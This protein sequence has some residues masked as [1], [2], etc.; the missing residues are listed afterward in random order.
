MEDAPQRLRSLT[1]DGIRDVL[2]GTAL[3]LSAQIQDQGEIQRRYESMAIT[4]TPYLDEA[5]DLSEAVMPY[6]YPPEGSENALELEAANQSLVAKGTINLS[7]DLASTIFPPNGNFFENRKT[8]ALEKQFEEQQAAAEAMSEEGE[9]DSEA[10]AAEVM[11]QITRINNLIIAR[12]EKIKS[13]IQ[14][15]PDAYNF[16][17]A[18]IHCVF[19]GNVCFAKP[20]L[21]SSKIYTL[22]DYVS[23]FDNTGE[24][25]EVIVRDAVHISKFEKRDLTNLFGTSDSTVFEEAGLT[26]IPVYTRQIRRYDHWE[27]Q[28]E[29]AGKRFKKME[30]KEELD[31]PPFIVM[32]FFLLPGKDY[33]IGWLTHN[34][35]DIIQFENMNLTLNTMIQA[36]SKLIAMFPVEM[37]LSKEEIEGRLGFQAHFGDAGKAQ[38]IYADISKNLGSI[39]TFYE[40]ARQTIMTAFL[41]NESVVRNAERVTQAEILEV[42]KGLKKILGGIYL[43]AG[44]RFQIPYIHRFIR[45]M[46]EAGEIPKIDE[47]D[48]KIQLTTGLE[49][50]EAMDEAQALDQWFARAQAAGPAAQQ[51]INDEEFLRR[52]GNYGHINLANL[53][54]SDEQQQEKLGATQLMGV[55]KQLGPQGPAIAAQLIT[56]AVSGGKLGDMLGAGNGGAIED[57]NQPPPQVPNEGVPQ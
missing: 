55:L 25:V 13:R 37:K 8:P 21:D 15:S 29:I 12:D 42:V 22:E 10:M 43:S 7:K 39:Q 28:I 6:L 49:T 11:G 54:M 33:G 14:Q 52:H 31:S 48:V 44:P 53:L 9:S 46:E 19:S 24:L 47:R 36:A 1:A 56:Q 57:P 4:R 26:E 16:Y 20:N 35:G 32:P 38:M 23:D 51:R 17:L 5:R 34:K 41:L 50:L 3:S 45:L 27:I 30:G 40:S 18:M 2:R